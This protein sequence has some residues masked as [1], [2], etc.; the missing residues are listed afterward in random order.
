MILKPRISVLLPVHNAV[1]FLPEALA[2]LAGQT[3]RDFEVIAVDD[4]STD[5]SGEFLGKFAVQHEWLRVLTQENVGIAVALNRALAASEGGLVARMDADDIADKKR[6]DLQAEFLEAHPRIGVCGSW[7]R[8]FGEGREAV[9]RAPV[10]DDAIRSWLI[11]GSAFVHPAVMMRREVLLGLEGPYRPGVEDY[12]LWMRLAETT[13]FHNLPEVLLKYR[14]HST[15]T[16]RLANDGRA[17]QAEKLRLDLLTRLGVNGSFAQQ[18]AH[19]ALGFETINGDRPQPHAVASW[20]E[21]LCQ[22]VPA[23]GWCSEEALRTDAADAWWR[24]MR[25]GDGGATAAWTYGRAPAAKRTSKTLFR[26]ARLAL[27]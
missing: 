21:F 15:Q 11:F 5:G 25:A 27:R 8:T 18:R 1:R 4:G 12:D 22:A 9:V 20:L 24:Y 6:F 26:M 10:W 2:S 19:G 7:A 16:T 23:S 13:R 17:R 14:R 3:R